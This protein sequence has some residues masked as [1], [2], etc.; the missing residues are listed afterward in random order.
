MTMTQRGFPTAELREEHERGVPNAFERLDKLIHLPASDRG[1]ARLGAVGLRAEPVLPMGLREVDYDGRSAPTVRS[2]ATRS[3]W[4][5]KLH[6]S[7]EKPI[8]RT[9]RAR[10]GAGRWIAAV[11]P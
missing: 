3:S 10:S 2:D 1:S 8:E 5:S 4:L 9:S 6:E 7:K 11:L